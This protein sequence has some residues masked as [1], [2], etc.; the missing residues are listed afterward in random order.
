METVTDFRVMSE[1]LL[2]K[3]NQGAKNVT[4]KVRK[5]SAALALALALH[6]LSEVL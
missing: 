4:N 5:S 1:A 6:V 2:L 3:A